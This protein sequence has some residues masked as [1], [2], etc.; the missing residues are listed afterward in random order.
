MTGLLKDKITTKVIVAINVDD[1]DKWPGNCLCLPGICLQAAHHQHWSD[2]GKSQTKLIDTDRKHLEG[3][4]VR[5]YKLLV[6][7]WLIYM[8]YLKNNYA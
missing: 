4:I 5:V 3:D 1:C 2:V 7:D 8:R 6:F